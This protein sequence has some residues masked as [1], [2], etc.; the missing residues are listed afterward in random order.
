MSAT[1][2]VDVLVVG[3][4]PAGCAA[5]VELARQGK[6]VLVCDKATFPRDKC[7]G[8]GLTTGALRRL[9]ALDV[10]VPGLPSWRAIDSVSVRSPSGRVARVPL[11][12]REGIFGGVCRREELDAALV[13][14]ARR[15]G[16]GV[17]EGRRFE[18][19]TWSGESPGVVAAFAAGPDVEAPFLL[20]ADGAWSPVRRAAGAAAADAGRAPY[21]GEW[22]AF[23]RYFHGVSSEAAE[24]LWI[25]FDREVLP[26]YAWSF[27]LAGGAANVGVTL[28]RQ[29]GTTGSDLKARA[30]AALSSPWFRSLAGRRAWTDGVE[31]SWPIPSR[32]SGSPLTA[33]EGRVLFL[34]D[35]ARL[36]DP[37][38]GEGVAQ[39]LESGAAAARAVLGAEPGPAARRYEAAVAAT[40]ARDNSLARRLSET[41]AI[42]VMARA[43]VRGTTLAGVRRHFGGWLFEDYPRALALTPRR[44]RRGTLGRPGAY[45]GRTA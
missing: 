30:A 1:R 3:A 32:T 18:R 10:D 23:R 44:W 11:P 41:I 21:L 43:A 42:P 35:A 6:E 24:H 39:A 27:P 36:A 33:L 17:E 8:D 26:G 5:A 13:A 25:W 16:A 7:C 29:A 28:R 45:P 38:T 15:A 20:A 9:E 37:L 4:G 14:A 12:A 22:H 19:L 2:R 31:R 34:G 40:L